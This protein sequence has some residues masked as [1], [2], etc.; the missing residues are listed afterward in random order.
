[1]DH[2]V[3]IDLHSNNSC[4]RII[5]NDNR[6][7]FRKK[8][9]KDL[10]QVLRILEPYWEQIKGMVVEST[11]NWYWLVDGLMNKG[12]KVQLTNSSAIK[13]YEGL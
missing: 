8:T 5:D 7:V 3:G 6:R 4:T 12:Y 1:M 2:F 13:Q 10:R 11:F 9:K